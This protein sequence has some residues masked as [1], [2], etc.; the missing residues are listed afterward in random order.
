MPLLQEHLDEQMLQP[1]HR[2]KY[3][4]MPWNWCVARPVCEDEI[5]QSLGAQ[6]ALRKEQDRLREIDAWVESE[7]EEWD[8]V[9]ARAKRTNTK[10]HMGM[11]FQI[12][13]EKD[14]QTEKPEHLRKWK[15][16][17]VFR[18]DDVVDENWD[19]AMSQ[20]LGSAPAAMVAAKMC[21]LYGLI[22]DHVI[23]NADSTQAYT[24][25]FLGGAKTWVSLSLLGSTRKDLFT[26]WS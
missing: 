21:D 8:V 12:C 17:V 16:R 15:G 2:Q 14:S 1:Q 19:V 26:H 25:S 6:A 20:E 22:R 5:R 11:V 9:K 23:A 10:I 3:N 7:V 13:V 24:Q 18:G 4:D